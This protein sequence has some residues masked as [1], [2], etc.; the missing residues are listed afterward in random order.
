MCVPFLH[1]QEKGSPTFRPQ[2]GTSCQISGSTTLKI[3]WTINV[4][5]LNYQETM[6]PP[7]AHGKIICHKIGPWC[8]KGQAPLGKSV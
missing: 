7:L 3:K 2:T 6:L 5:H 4:M 1:G 8:Q